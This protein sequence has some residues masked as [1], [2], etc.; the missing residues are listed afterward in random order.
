MVTH[1]PL[2][3]SDIESLLSISK[4]LKCDQI[5]YDRTYINPI[6]GIGPEKSYFQTTSYMVDLSPHL[7]NLLID[8]SDLKNIDKITQLQPS[9]ENPEIAIHQPVV[10][11]SNIDAFQI[12]CIMDSLRKYEIDEN[13]AVRD[14]NFHES[15][16]YKELMSSSASS[17][18]CRLMIDGYYIDLPKSA[19]PT[20]KSDKVEA[21]V[22][23][24]T[25]ARQSILRLKITKRNGI[26]INQ[27]FAFIPY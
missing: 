14:E 10:S 7:D 19:I 16:C 2:T 3:Q 8:V 4:L 18:V 17:G 25:G 9:I 26:I 12:Q 23:N 13:I 11:V 5:L 24:V 6:I 1:F 22:Y 20:V 15:Y 21:T 27:S